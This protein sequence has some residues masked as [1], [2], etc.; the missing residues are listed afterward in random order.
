M[1]LRLRALLLSFCTLPPHH[2]S[3]IGISL[4]IEYA[5]YFNLFMSRFR[6]F[7]FHYSEFQMFFWDIPILLHQLFSSI[8]QHHIPYKRYITT[9]FVLPNT[10]HWEIVFP[11]S[12]DVHAH[13][14]NYDLRLYCPIRCQYYYLY[15]SFQFLYHYYECLHH[16]LDHS[17]LF[18]FSVAF[19]IYRF[20][21]FVF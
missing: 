19:V 5:S 9:L 18:M 6:V 1:T 17:F 15:R 12:L 11:I 2:H 7:F 21:R 14:N 20:I 3:C 13:L 10:V 4:F 8:P 16:Y